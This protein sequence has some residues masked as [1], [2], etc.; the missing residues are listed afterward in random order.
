ME[1]KQIVLPV[2][3]G[4][5]KSALIRW[6]MEGRCLNR[7]ASHVLGFSLPYFKRKKQE[8]IFTLMDFALLAPACDYTLALVDNKTDEVY[9]LGKFLKG[10]SE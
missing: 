8:D 2:Y 9:D 10:E 1:C 3:K 5:R 7:K 6:M 4:R